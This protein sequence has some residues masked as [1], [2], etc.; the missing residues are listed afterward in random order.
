MTIDQNYHM[1]PAE[2]RRWGHELIDWIADYRQ[3]VEEYPVLSQVE[4]GDIRAARGGGGPPPPPPGGRGGGGGGA[5]PP[6][7]PPGGVWGGGG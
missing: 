4:P 5:A 7:P 1:T 3:R 2:F 6:P